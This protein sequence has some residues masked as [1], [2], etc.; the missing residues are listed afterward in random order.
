M[1]RLLSVRQQDIVPDF[2]GRPTTPLPLTCAYLLGQAS[3]EHSADVTIPPELVAPELG[4]NRI[5]VTPS[6]DLNI[7]HMGY[8]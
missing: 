1:I 3:S 7:G 2:Q 5:C 8:P 4:L 6:Q